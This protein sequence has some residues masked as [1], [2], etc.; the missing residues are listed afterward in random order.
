MLT[1]RPRRDQTVRATQVAEVVDLD[2]QLVQ[3]LGLQIGRPAEVRRR[4]G[5]VG[6]Q[7]PVAKA[8]VR[9]RL[10]MQPGASHIEPR[11]VGVVANHL[12]EG[13]P[14]IEPAQQPQ[15]AIVGT[16]PVRSRG[17]ERDNVIPDVMHRI[18][19]C[20]EHGLVFNHDRHSD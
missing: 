8:V 20:T 14:T 18:G 4:G 11:R 7:K 16:D 2:P 19:R 6:R 12:Y 15:P 9:E 10:D 17:I 3:M 5:A 1:L 13:G